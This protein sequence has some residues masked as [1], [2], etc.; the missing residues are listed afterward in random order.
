[1]CKMSFNLASLQSKGW[2]EN[3]TSQLVFQTPGIQRWTRPTE[4]TLQCALS[5][6][7]YTPDSTVEAN[8]HKY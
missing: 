4:R 7:S 6:L 3:L 2:R 1:M 8:T 5:M